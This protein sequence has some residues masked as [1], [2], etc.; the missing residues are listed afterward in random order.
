MR[1]LTVL[2]FFIEMSVKCGINTELLAG[3]ITFASQ[4]ARDSRIY[5][6]HP[7]FLGTK[8]AELDQ[9]LHINP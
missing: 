2:K 1:T 8:L 9:I 7:T 4:S 3:L 6:Y 5:R